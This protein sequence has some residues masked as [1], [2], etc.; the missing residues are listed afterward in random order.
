M[1]SDSKKLIPSGTYASREY[2]MGILVQNHF[3]RT[4]FSQTHLKFAS[5][6]AF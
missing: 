4:T 2:K 1:D 3:F 5:Y 6:W